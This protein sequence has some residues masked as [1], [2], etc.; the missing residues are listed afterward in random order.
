MTDVRDVMTAVIAQHEECAD[1]PPSLVVS[2]RR[3]NLIQRVRDDLKLPL[4]LLTSH[5]REIKELLLERLLEDP[6]AHTCRGCLSIP[7]TSHE[8]RAKRA[9]CAVSRAIIPYIEQ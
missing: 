5:E 4:H 2:K 3:L 8:I 1:T 7:L 9:W 6:E